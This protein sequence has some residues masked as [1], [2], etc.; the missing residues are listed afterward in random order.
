MTKLPLTVVFMALM[1]SAFATAQGVSAPP[2]R[3]PVPPPGQ[4]IPPTQQKGTGAI[5]GVVID[6]NTKRP[7]AGALVY[8]GIQNYGVVRPTTQQLKQ[9]AKSRELIGN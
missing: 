6:G 9:K 2:G 7:I 8:L 1:G 4:P 5:S 3:P